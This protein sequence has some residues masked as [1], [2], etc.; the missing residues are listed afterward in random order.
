MNAA[1]RSPEL[2]IVEALVACGQS[3]A[4]ALKL[5]NTVKDAVRKRVLA[6]TERRDAIAGPVMAGLISANVYSS[7]SQA[8]KKAV[9][10]ADALLVE[11]DK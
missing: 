2:E 4:S 11:L 9:E 8:A 6:S 1:T 5:V 7:P 3:R 10:Y